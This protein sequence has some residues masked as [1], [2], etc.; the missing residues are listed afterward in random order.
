[1]RAKIIQQTK[2]STQNAPIGNFG[3]A[4]EFE[5]LERSVYTDKTTGWLSTNDTNT[6][7]K[8]KFST[9][10]EA[11]EYAKHN[12]IEYEIIEAKPKKLVKKLY[13]DNFK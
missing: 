4:I 5:P 12:K 10:S 3:W 2:A 8:L 11:E 6:E 9:L 7:L 1:M 13:A